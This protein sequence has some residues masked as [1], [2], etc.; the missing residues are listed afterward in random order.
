MQILP[1]KI[2]LG[3]PVATC[4]LAKSVFKLMYLLML[5]WAFKIE[6]QTHCPTLNDHIYFIL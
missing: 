3:H 5:Y 4:Y 1:Q 2:A 6:I